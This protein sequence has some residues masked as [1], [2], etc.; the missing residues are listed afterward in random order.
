[1]DDILIPLAINTLVQ[2]ARQPGKRSKFRK[3]LLK[4]FVEIAKA[5]KNDAEF[6]AEHDRVVLGGS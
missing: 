5:F 1:M 3:Q 4:V 2:L 6:A